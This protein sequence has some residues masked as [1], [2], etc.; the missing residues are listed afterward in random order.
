LLEDAGK[1]VGVELRTG[2]DTH[3]YLDFKFTRFRLAFVFYFGTSSPTTHML[4]RKH[5]GFL[6]VSL[7]I[8]RHRHRHRHLEV[9]LTYYSSLPFVSLAVDDRPLLTGADGSSLPP[10][11][12]HSIV[13]RQKDRR[14]RKKLEA[15]GYWGIGVRSSFSSAG[16]G[17]RGYR[18]GQCPLSICMPLALSPVHRP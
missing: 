1:R 17:V 15:R 13:T 2:K 8:H 4:F 7:N 5:Q 9:D 6:L 16:Y 10:F 12:S 18:S 11:R 3:L 14:R